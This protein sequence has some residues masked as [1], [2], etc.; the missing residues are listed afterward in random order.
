M[1]M[2]AIASSGEELLESREEQQILRQRLAFL[3]LHWHKWGYSDFYVNCSYGL[4]LWAA[5]IICQLKRHMDIRLHIVAPHEEQCAYWKEENRDRYMHVHEKADTIRFI[6]K[7]Y[8]KDCNERADEFMVDHC[9]LVLLYSDEGT[10]AYIETC[11]ESAGIG[12]VYI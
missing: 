7:P 10:T 3:I 5:E 11:A 8:Q 9:G 12:L 6:G 4:P 2:C 1:F